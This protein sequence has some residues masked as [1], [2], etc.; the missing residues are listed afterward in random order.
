MRHG[1]RSIGIIGFGLMGGSLARQLKDQD[2]R[3]SIRGWARNPEDLEE[4]IAL[5]ALDEVAPD[6]VRVFQASDLVVLATPL[7]PALGI[8][9]AAAG[10]LGPETLLSDV[11]S[12]KAPLVQKVEDLG[13]SPRYVGAHP[14]VGGEGSGFAASRPDLYS[15]AAVWLVAAQATDEARASVKAFWDSLGAQTKWIGAEVHDERMAW[16]SHLPQLTSNALAL[17]LEGEGMARSE[18]GPGGRDMTRLAG[19]SSDMWADLLSE[20]GPRAARALEV[21]RSNLRTLESDL[22]NR[23][24]QAIAER[25]EQT[26]AWSEEG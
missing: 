1:F 20:A 4:G 19:S 8:L 13:L 22:R 14:M 3:L 12:L 15:G 5:G 9:E 11:I 21:L 18:L 7:R 2:P 25:M 24:S 10:H 6:V 17:S 16:L 23:D 26:R